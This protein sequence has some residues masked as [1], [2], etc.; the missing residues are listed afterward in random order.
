MCSKTD[1]R[2]GT[3]VF[4]VG[5]QGPV[6]L[7]P[8]GPA[9]GLCAKEHAEMHLQNLKSDERSA[10]RIPALAIHQNHPGYSKNYK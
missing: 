1:I 7:W 6:A 4:V 9:A 8:Q 3:R 10:Q 5:S 2:I